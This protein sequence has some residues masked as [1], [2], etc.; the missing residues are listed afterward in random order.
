MPDTNPARGVTAENLAYVIY[1][2][3]S[4]GCPK[5]VAVEHRQIVNYVRGICER[6][7]FEPAWHFAIVST[8]AAD[9][10][11][12]VLFPSV[13][14]GGCLHVISKE[15]AT[16]SA[17]LAEYFERNRIDCLKIVPSHLAALMTGLHPRS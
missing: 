11:N 14:T 17:A 8:I 3:G 5:G 10:G 13:C 2:S 4:T 12:T 1:T 6:M 9:L 16:D 7:E 15:R